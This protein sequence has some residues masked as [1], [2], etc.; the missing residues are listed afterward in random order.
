MMATY[1]VTPTMLDDCER[2]DVY[3]KKLDVWAL[4]MP[5]LKVQLGALVAASIPNQS[6]RYKKYLQDKLFEQIKGVD[7][8][9][10]EGF[11]KELGE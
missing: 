11:D 10:E 4:T 3:M 5:V 6:M 9:S 1:K 7:L 2:F 8:T